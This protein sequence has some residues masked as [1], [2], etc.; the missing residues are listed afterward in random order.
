VATSSKPTLN[1]TAPLFGRSLVRRS[2]SV[3]FGRARPVPPMP[4]LRNAPGVLVGIFAHAGLNFLLVMSV[5]RW[6]YGVGEAHGRTAPFESG[7]F[8]LLVAAVGFVAT[9]ALWSR[10]RSKKLARAG[11]LSVAIA[12][13]TV[14]ATWFWGFA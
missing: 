12:V 13:A 7:A 9:I 11:A 6:I 5:G 3:S 8:L 14:A 4:T 10:M 2:T 1:L